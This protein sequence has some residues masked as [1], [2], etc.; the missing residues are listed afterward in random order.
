MELLHK[1]TELLK[2]IE[3][4]FSVIL[5]ILIRVSGVPL[6]SQFTGLKDLHFF[7]VSRDVIGDL[8]PSLISSF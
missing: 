5:D 7:V 4:F 8:I 6:G 3:K 2:E 1:R